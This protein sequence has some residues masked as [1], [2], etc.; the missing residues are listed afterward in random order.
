MKT[1]KSGPKNRKLLFEA[2]VKL[3]TVEECQRFFEDLCTPAELH[4]MAGRWEV[5]KLVEQKVPYR[6][7]HGLTGVSTATVT[8]VAR[9]LTKE[10]SGYARLL[11]R[12]KSEE[13]SH[14]R[15]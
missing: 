7:I 2:I 14:E 15:K 13:V 8:R 5:A 10:G 12:I 6:T 9:A 4:A 3:R 11:T 1:L